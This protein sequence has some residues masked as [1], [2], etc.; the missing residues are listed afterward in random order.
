MKITNKNNLPLPVYEAL[1]WDPEYIPVEKRY[2]VSDLL[3]PIQETILKRKHWGEIEEDAS[4]MIWA[5]FGQGVHAA[6]EGGVF[7]KE[8][9]IKSHVLFSEKK[10]EYDFGGCTVVGKADLV[11][12]ENGK[13]VLYDYKVTSVWGIVFNSQNE[14]WRR[15]LNLYN[16]LLYKCEG[17]KADR[18][19]VFAI[20]RDWSKRRSIA[21]K[22]Y[23]KSQTAVLD[24]PICKFEKIEK[25]VKEKL[26]LLCAKK[27]IDC[28]EEEKWA[29]PDRWAVKKKGKKRALR[30]LDSKEDAER[31][32]HNSGGGYIEFRKGEN[33]KCANYC[34]A[35]PFCEQRRKENAG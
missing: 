25:F 29:K 2:S 35:A 23:P 22:D 21:E 24:F 19:R 4:G 13:I 3:A 15:Q 9:K 26:E 18:L 16:W 27:I 17:I 34:V 31:Y 14:A 32:I 11:C 6:L 20:I 1:L 5:L 10:W 28:T 12:K 30:V 8:G 7:D 33:G